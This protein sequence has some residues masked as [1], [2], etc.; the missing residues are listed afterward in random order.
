MIWTPTLY[1]VF[2]LLGALAGLYA[3]VMCLYLLTVWR[4]H[5][6]WQSALWEV[7]K[8]M[9]ICAAGFLALCV[10]GYLCGN[11]MLKATTNPS[12]N[13]FGFLALG[14]LLGLMSGTLAV[15]RA[16]WRARRRST[17]AHY[18]LKSLGKGTQ[19]LSKSPPDRFCD[20]VMKGGITSGVVYPPA[21]CK[22]AEQYVFKNIGGTSAGAIAA[23][24]TAA[25]EYRRR[26]TGSMAG[27][28]LVG[29]LPVELG[30]PGA[31]GN[32]QLL[33][34]FQPDPSCRR[35]FRILIGS[36]NASGTF[37]RIGSILRCCVTSYWPATL[38]SIV[39][40]VLIGLYTG[41][42]HA[43]ILILLTSLLLCSCYLNYTRLLLVF[44]TISP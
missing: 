34:L 13:V 27:F 36:L 32:T 2:F 18:S 40:S 25:A 43:G 17:V 11:S 4:S 7:C 42:E 12:D 33:R 22:L 15:V 1:L 37:H 20:I 30:T 23:A 39:G 28:D 9:V 24:L 38:V 31:A 10:V 41:S 3:P 29:A 44:V 21:I 8:K 14:F 5:T 35:L 6:T 19:M 16:I 26:T